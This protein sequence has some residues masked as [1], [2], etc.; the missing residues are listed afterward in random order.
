MQRLSNLNEIKPLAKSA[1]IHYIKGDAT[2]PLITEGEYS[3]ICHCCNTL[4]AWGA[5]FVLALSKRFPKV[6]EHYLSLIKSIKPDERLGKVGFVKTNKNIV[7]ANILGQDR[8]YRSAD[9]KIPLNYEAL[10]EGFKNVYDKFIDYKNI[11]F[12]I[13]MPR[14]GCGLAGGKW[15]IV[16]DII[17][18]KITKKG[19]EVYVYDYNEIK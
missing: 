12:T 8:I 13:H 14:I 16:E 11:P 5:G 15:E 9:G 17:K 4:G 1:Q 19:V 7:V 10:R 18:K 3:V 2:K 6:K